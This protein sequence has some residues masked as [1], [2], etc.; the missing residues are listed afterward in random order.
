MTDPR[1]DTSKNC[2]NDALDAVP[3]SG[4]SP[5][6]CFIPNWRIPPQK[7]YHQLYAKELGSTKSA[8]RLVFWLLV[9]FPAR[10]DMILHRC[11]N[12]YCYNPFHLYA[13]GQAENDR[14]KALHQQAAE[15][16]KA[17]MPRSVVLSAEVCRL[18][19]AFP[20][21]VPDRCLH[22]NWL[23]STDDGFKQLKKTP[24]SGEVVGA[25]RKIY[26]LFKGPLDKYDIVSHTCHDR[27][28]L[29]PYH[30]FLSGRQPCTTNF[31]ARHDKNCKLSG[32][33]LSEIATFP[34]SVSE[35]A[36]K[37]GVHPITIQNRR[38]E[39][40]Q[41]PVMSLSKESLQMSSQSCDASARRVADI[42][43]DFPRR[44]LLAS[45][46]GAAPKLA[47][48]LMADGTYS[49]LASDAEY[50]EAYENA[51]DLAQNLKG[52]VLRKERENRDWTRE[53]NLARTRRGVESKMRTGVWDLEPGE[54]TWV[55]KR[56]VELLA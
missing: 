30:L 12:R 8:H 54:L 49:N 48:R 19:A 35:L 45:L 25:H 42:P 34:L 37:F 11:G 1:K 21:V 2:P 40:R 32:D 29:N 31:N 22:S 53:F 27:S 13:G 44:T 15:R 33:D 10:E 55:M 24:D 23:A 3:F 4:V 5:E 41:K 52:Y 56:L 47:V 51:E 20:G 6:S 18:A 36:K 38:R 50:L 39:M 46:P 43:K 17:H 7:G 26:Q 28:C 9:G 14:D 16:A